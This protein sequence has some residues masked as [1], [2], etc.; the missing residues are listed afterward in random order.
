[1]TPEGKVKNAVKKI[2]TVS[3][4]YFCMPFG[5]GYG[6]AGVADIVACYKGH[7]LAIECKAGKGKTTALQDRE[8]AAVG[9]AGG[10]P[11]VINESNIED[12]LTTLE[13]FDG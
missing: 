13:K 1:M 7:F 6:R 10:T 9:A 3:G 4:A 11:L 8:L 2:L 5:A 12:V